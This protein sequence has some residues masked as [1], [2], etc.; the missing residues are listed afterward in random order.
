ML[1]F[2]ADQTSRHARPASYPDDGRRFGDQ[3][4]DNVLDQRHDDVPQQSI[5]A[6]HDVA[7]ERAAET[8]NLPQ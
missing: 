5:E 4:D 8:A 3:P 2:V 6:R 1:Q 7:D